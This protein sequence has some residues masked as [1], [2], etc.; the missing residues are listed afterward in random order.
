MSILR[1]R[2]QWGETDA[3]GIVF[4]PNYFRWFD[5]ATHQ[6]FRQAGYPIREMLAAGSAIPLIGSGANFTSP[7]RYDDEIE[8][9]S[10][11][12]EVRTRAFRVRHIIRR[13]GEAV[14]DGYEIRIFAGVG[15]GGVLAPGRIPDDIR[16]ILMKELSPSDGSAPTE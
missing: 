8:I 10:S 6:L 2:V 11:V 15:N 12:A 3:A 9:E 7:L 4:Y 5:R 13:E 14:A 16:R 1:H